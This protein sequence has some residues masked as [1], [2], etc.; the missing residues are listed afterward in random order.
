MTK[1]NGS[2]PTPIVKVM[3]MQ[4]NEGPRLAR[5]LTHYAALFGMSNLLIFDNGSDDPY[6]HALLDEAERCGAHVRRD[7]NTP[8]DFQNKGGHFTN[9]IRSLNHD[10]EYDFALPVDCDELLCAFTEDGLSMSKE[11]VMNELLRLKPLD[12]SFLIELSLFNLPGLEN[13][14]WYAPHRHFQKGFVPAY[15]DA[16]IDNGHHAPS[17]AHTTE[18]RATR[19][20]Y[21][22]SH[23]RPYEEMLRLC[24][25]KLIPE[26]DHPDDVLDDEK[27]LEYIT[28]PGCPGSHLGYML[29]KTQEE[30]ENSYKDEVQLYFRDGLTLIRTKDGQLRRWDAAAYLERHPDVAGYE[31]GPLAHYLMH[32]AREGRS[33]S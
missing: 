8:F 20:V 4:K 13:E 25:N 30:Y 12:C 27:I 18:L 2:N 7:L 6:T 33:L 15:R 32:G 24:R 26:M 17:L 11:D 5:W 21:L 29:L 10:A 16:M 9:I 31:S 14:G 3:M 22:H 1:I 19:F 23:N 28:R